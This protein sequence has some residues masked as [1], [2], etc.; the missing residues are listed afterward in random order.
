MKNYLVQILI[1]VCLAFVL[2]L[3]LELG[4]AKVDE[5]ELKLRSVCDSLQH[6]NREHEL[7]IMQLEKE[8]EE[9]TDALSDCQ[10]DF[11]DCLAG[12]VR[13]RSGDVRPTINPKY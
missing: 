12:R 6:A 7:R 9:A 8:I 2:W 1:F 11:Q 4:T 13:Y 3:G 10:E 5:R